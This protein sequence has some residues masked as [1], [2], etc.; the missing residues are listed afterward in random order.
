MAD[1]M[2]DI[3]MME[4]FVFHSVSEY[5]M[6]QMGLGFDNPCENFPLV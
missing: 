5:S 4:S 6:S 3:R 1:A 2:G